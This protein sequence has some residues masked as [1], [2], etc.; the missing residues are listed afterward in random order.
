MSAQLQGCL[1]AL[2]IPAEYARY[3]TLTDA[4]SISRLELWKVRAQ[5]TLSDLRNLVKRS[6]A[7]DSSDTEANLSLEERS[8]IIYTV[9]GFDGRRAWSTDDAT[10]LAEGDFRGLSSRWT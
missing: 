1:D 8:Q 7:V 3:E 9:A 4:E 10:R 2:R 5:E 6:S